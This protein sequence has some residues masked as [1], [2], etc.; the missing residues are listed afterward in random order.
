LIREREARLLRPHAA[1]Y[2]KLFD[3]SAARPWP[4]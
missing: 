4:R 2:I 3:A 1:Q